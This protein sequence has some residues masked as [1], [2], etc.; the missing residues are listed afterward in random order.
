MIDKTQSAKA[1]LKYVRAWRD[2]PSAGQQNLI[3]DILKHK[4]FSQGGPQDTYELRHIPTDE[5]VAPYGVVLVTGLTSGKRGKFLYATEP[6]VGLNTDEFEVIINGGKALGIGDCGW[7]TFGYKPCLA[8]VSS[9]VSIGDQVGPSHGD[10]TLMPGYPGFR[11]LGASNLTGIG[12][13]LRDRGPAMGM[14]T[15]ITSSG[16]TGTPATFILDNV[17]FSHGFASWDGTSDF[18]VTNVFSDTAASGLKVQ[19]KWDAYT[20][21]YVSTDVECA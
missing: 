8:A 13:V 2:R 19:F 10:S 3:V 4:G 14:G 16:Q 11:Y 12:W 9:A 7:G 21:A 5:A 20:G 18:E 1:K 17:S 6:F 15:I